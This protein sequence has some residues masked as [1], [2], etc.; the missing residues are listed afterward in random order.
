M[1]PE[2]LAHK[3]KTVSSLGKM[4]VMSNYA[5]QQYWGEVVQLRFEKDELEAMKAKAMAPLH[6]KEE[7]RKG[8]G[9]MDRLV[10]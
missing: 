5:M 3:F 9:R 7:K 8:R 6:G 4:R 1:M 2:A 10:D